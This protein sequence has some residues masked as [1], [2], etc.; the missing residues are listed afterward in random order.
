[1]HPRC[2]RDLRPYGVLSDFLV[3]PVQCRCGGVE[4][5]T[6]G[7]LVIRAGRTLLGGCPGLELARERKSSQKTTVLCVSAGELVLGYSG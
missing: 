2:H 6:F 5:R 7:C 4:C 1:M 3:N